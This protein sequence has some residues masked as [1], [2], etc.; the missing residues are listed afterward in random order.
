MN[1]RR[2]KQVGRPVYGR[3]QPLGRVGRRGVVKRPKLSSTGKRIL[4]LVATVLVVGW[5]ILQLFTLNQIHVTAPGRGSEIEKSA[6]T[7]IDSQWRMG[8]LLTLDSRALAAKLEERDPQLRDV[9][10]QRKWPHGVSISTTLKQPSLGWSTGNQVYVLDRDGVVIGNG[11]VPSS[12]PVVFDGSN[13]PVTL[14]QRVVSPHFVEFANAVVP[15]LAVKGLPV[16]RL[17]IKDTTIDLTVQTAKGFRILLDTGRGV[18]E[19]MSD[20]AAVQR[21]LA[22]QKRTPAEYID[23]R[24][25]GKAYYK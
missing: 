18:E 12:M 2:V 10:V 4:G 20:L 3:A 14:G 13:L 21:L 7:I 8:N 17:D 23:L 6:R 22:T 5:G 11:P 16:T 15:A 9:R 1:E 19:E 25:S 24:I